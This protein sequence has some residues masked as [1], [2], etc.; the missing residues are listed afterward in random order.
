MTK[1]SF[2]AEEI[3]E[4]AIVCKHCARDPKDDASQV[5]LVAPK[6]ETGCAAWGCLTLI[7]L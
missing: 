6:Q 5:Q 3:Q 2:C 7:V 1:C 4:A